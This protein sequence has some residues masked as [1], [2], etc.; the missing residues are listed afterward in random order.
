V[1]SLIGPGTNLLLGVLLTIPFWFGVD[2]GAH[3]GFWSGVAFLAFLQ[4]TAG[5]LNLVPLPGLDGGNALR[6]W[7]KEPWNRRFDLFAPYGLLILFVLLW[8]PLVNIIFFGFIELLSSVI[9]LDFDLA[10]FSLDVFRFWS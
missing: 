2:I 4:L 7:L 8:E 10:M 1:I 3:L 5:I 9:G 6:P